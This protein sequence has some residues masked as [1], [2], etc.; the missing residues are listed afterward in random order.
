MATREGQWPKDEK[1]QRKLDAQH[2]HVDLKLR[3]GED[4]Q[5]ISDYPSTDFKS[6]FKDS[7]LCVWRG[8]KE[9]LEEEQRERRGINDG[10]VGG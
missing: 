3:T 4:F 9:D 7:F 2:Q 5:Y 1:R 6:F 10:G 8:A